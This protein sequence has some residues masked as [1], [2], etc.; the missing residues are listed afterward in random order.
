VA[1]ADSRARLYD[2][3]WRRTQTALSDLDST[4][5]SALVDLVRIPSTL[6]NERL[7]QEFIRDRAI[8]AGLETELWDVDPDALRLDPRFALAYDGAE[9]RPNVTGVVRGS[10]EGRSFALSGHID[11][12]S[13]EPVHL[14]RHDPWGGVVE[15]GRLYG[16]GALDMKGGLI[17]ALHAIHAIHEAGVAL[18]GDIFFE[19]VIEEECTGNGM[20]AARLRGEPVDAALIPEITQEEVHVATV[21]VLWFELSF[22]G[23]PGYVGRAQESINAVDLAIHAIDSLR[24]LPAELNSQLNHPLYADYPD[25]LT[26]N[27]GTIHAGD[28]PSNVPQSCV[29]GVR[30]SFPPDWPAERA[31]TVIEAR[32]H[33]ISQAH[34]W[35]RENPPALRYHGF[36]AKGWSV[37]LDEP[38]VRLTASAYQA[39][40]GT[41]ATVKPA[42]GTADAR[43][44]GDAGTPAVY[45]GPAGGN[46]H[47]PDEFVE[48]QSVA[49]VARVL[50]R[51]VLGWSF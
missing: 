16:R 19:S 10:G 31:Q 21:G 9:L 33:S 25:A 46:M 44:F 27:I 13:P 17:A 35:L 34:P 48:L 39:E 11:V 29:V 4:Y 18:R 20:L 3:A 24:D 15:A 36:R 1:V 50:A 41:D 2:D 7:A 38:I 49:L 26:L 43:Y 45:F 37:G 12:V 14:W 5:R 40:T 23:R 51:V 47:A 42:F 6:G 30:C 8:A 22:R 28:W 32:I